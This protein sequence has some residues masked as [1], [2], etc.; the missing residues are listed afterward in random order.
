MVK[1]HQQSLGQGPTI[2]LVHGWAMHSGIWK[3]FAEKLAQHH[4]VICLDLPGHGQSEALED[5]NLADISA[6]LV[7]A[8]PEGQFCWLGWSSLRFEPPTLKVRC[9]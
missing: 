8:V 4:R 1:I 6:A 3:D 9:W 5:F 7:A 2:V